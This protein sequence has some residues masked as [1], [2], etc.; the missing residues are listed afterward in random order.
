MPA[1]CMQR[2]DSLATMLFAYNQGAGARFDRATDLPDGQNRF[3]G[4]MPASASNRKITCAE[5]LIS[6]TTSI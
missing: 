1:A 3:A 6:Q 2:R 5:N 4:V